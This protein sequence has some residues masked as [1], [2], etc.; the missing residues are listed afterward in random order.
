MRCANRARL[1]E[2]FMNGERFSAAAAKEAGLVDYTCKPEGLQE[3]A[4]EKARAFGRAAP[5]AQGVCKQLFRDVPL[6][7]LDKAERYAAEVLTKL[8]AGEEAR[9]GIAAFFEKRKI[10]WE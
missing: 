10:D 6:M 9:R 4:F 2:Y 1:K 3:A 8:A 7:P 5:K